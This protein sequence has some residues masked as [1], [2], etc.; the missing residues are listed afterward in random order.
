MQRDRKVSNPI[1]NQSINQSIEHFLVSSEG[2]NSAQCS[3]QTFFLYCAFSPSV[4]LTLCFSFALCSNAKIFHHLRIP[5]IAH[6]LSLLS[7]QPDYVICKGDYIS[8]RHSDNLADK[9]T[10]AV[11]ASLIAS[12]TVLKLYR[13][14]YV[15]SFCEFTITLLPSS[16]IGHNIYDINCT[17]I[18]YCDIQT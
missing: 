2:S 16:T 14:C 10:S 9:S 17:I 15:V 4:A 7:C 12:E 11:T 18:R 5:D 3:R 1:V 13:S 8:C 6:L